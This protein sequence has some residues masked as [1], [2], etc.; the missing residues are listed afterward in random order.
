VKPNMKVVVAAADGSSRGRV[1]TGVCLF[2]HTISQIP[3][4]A[5]ARITKLDIQMFYD[6]Y[7]KHIYFGIKV[8]S[9]KNSTSLG[10]YSLMCAG[11]C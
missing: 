11:L 7:W 1:F 3:K 5:V 10:L 6:G 4:T 9:H 2:V 8:T